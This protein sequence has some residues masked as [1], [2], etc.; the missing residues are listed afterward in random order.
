[1]TINCTMQDQARVEADL[2]EAVEGFCGTAQ[3]SGAEVDLSVRAR[4]HMGEGK[5]PYGGVQHSATKLIAIG[6]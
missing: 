1:M 2:V 3:V 6:R 4:G 5:A